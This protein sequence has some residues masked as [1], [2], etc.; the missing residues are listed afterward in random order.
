MA[1]I[2][3]YVVRSNTDCIEGRGDQFTLAV[4]AS[5]V[6]AERLSKGKYVQGT[7]CPIE[8]V[9]V[10]DI[11]G[12]RYVPLRVVNIIYPTADDIKL[13]CERV[14]YKAVF[15]KAKALGLTFEE[16]SALQHIPEEL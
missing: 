6:T 12:K 3:L 4:C 13:E 14:N 9:E 1:E 15:E 5:S 2:T 11:D 16:I 8:R 10:V 7:D